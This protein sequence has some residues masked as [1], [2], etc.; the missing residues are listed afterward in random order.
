MK[1]VLFVLVAS[2]EQAGGPNGSL[3]SQLERLWAY[4]ADHGIEIVEEITQMGAVTPFP[5]N[6]LTQYLQQHP[7]V[8]TVLVTDPS[9]IVHDPH[10]LILLEKLVESK[11]LQTHLVESGEV[12]RKDNTPQEW[13]FRWISAMV[14]S[15]YI[16]NLS[17]GIIKAQT[18]KAEMGRYPGP[19]PFGY[20]FDRKLGALVEDPVEAPL[21]KEVYRRYASGQTSLRS[22]HQDLHNETGTKMTLRALLRILT[23]TFYV[24]G[25]VWRGREYSG[26]HPRLIDWDTYSQVQKL[27]SGYAKK[28]H[29]WRERN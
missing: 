13:F 6:P 28:A 18:L 25:F 20:R 26:N 9:R 8:L 2:Y 24:G 5:L 14:A 10:D 11:N 4:A 16:A 1:A 22:L 7:D 12:F 17:E 15:N 3:M 21:V 23:S 19:P 27:L 29:T